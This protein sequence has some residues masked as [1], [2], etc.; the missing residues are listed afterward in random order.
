MTLNLRF[1]NRPPRWPCKSNC[2]SLTSISIPLSFCRFRTGQLVGQLHRWLSIDNSAYAS[3]AICAEHKYNGRGYGI[4]GIDVD[5][6]NERLPSPHRY[7]RRLLRCT[8]SQHSETL[9]DICRCFR[10]WKHRLRQCGVRKFRIRHSHVFGVSSVD[11]T[12]IGRGS[13][14]QPKS[15]PGRWNL[16]LF[17][18][19]HVQ[20]RGAKLSRTYCARRES[21]AIV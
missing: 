9:S 7:R 4:D 5:V 15:L 16:S 10:M 8:S 11:C 3:Q 20:Q 2:F 14:H 19:S 18:Q 1:L 21:F 13:Q 17:R 6:H 12:R